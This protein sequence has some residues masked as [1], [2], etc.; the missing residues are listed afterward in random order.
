M[1]PFT[2]RPLLAM[3][4]V[5]NEAHRYLKFVLDRLSEYVDGIVVLDDASTD[6]TPEICQNHN[7]VIGYHRLKEPLFISNEAALRHLLWEKTVEL[8]P[9]WVMAI[10]ADEFFESG[11]KQEISNITRQSQLDLFFFTTYHF[12]GNLS[13]YRVDGLWGPLFSKT[14]CL[15]RFRKDINYHWPNRKLH[16]GR[17]PLECYQ[18]PGSIS[19]IPLLHLGYVKEEDHLHKFQRYL[20][21]DPEGKFCPITHYRSITNPPHLKKWTGERLANII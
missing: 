17:F 3:L 6:E 19:K 14:P 7:C 10:D 12:W 8:N 13:Y 2:E 21:L 5:H 11:I 4:P 1:K 18:S 16:C 15:Y 9:V 20:S